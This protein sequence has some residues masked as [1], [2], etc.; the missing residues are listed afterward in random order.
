VNAD[1]EEDKKYFR[2]Q[3]GRCGCGEEWVQNI[4]RVI[5]YRGADVKKCSM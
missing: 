3:T 5:L 1:G 4:Y 2:T